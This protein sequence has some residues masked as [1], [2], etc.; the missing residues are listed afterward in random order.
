MVNEFIVSG[1]VHETLLKGRM[2]LID[3]KSS[4]LFVQDKRPLTVSSFLL[5]VITKIVHKRMNKVYE[6]EVVYTLMPVQL[7]A[8][9]IHD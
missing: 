4:S 9:Q 7:S 5:S 1:R 6:R 8:E 2:M 3:K